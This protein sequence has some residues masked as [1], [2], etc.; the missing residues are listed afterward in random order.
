MGGTSGGGEARWRGIY[1]HR[2]REVRARAAIRNHEIRQIP[3]AGGVWFRLRRLLTGAER[4]LLISPECAAELLA[5]GFAPEAVGGELEPPKTI[6][7]VPESRARRVEGAR[8][9]RPA[10]S[11]EVLSA[12]AIA[13]V[14]FGGR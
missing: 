9:V 1:E 14:R 4:V 7:A 10:L 12:P 11:A 13:I 2:L 3:H 5:E 6:V 8:E